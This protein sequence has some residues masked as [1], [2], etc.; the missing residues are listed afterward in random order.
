MEYWIIGY[1]N[2]TFQYSN[3]PVIQFA[4]LVADNSFFRFSRSQRQKII[5]DGLFQSFRHTL[6]IQFLLGLSAVRG[7]DFS[8]RESALP[9]R[10]FAFENDCATV[11]L[12]EQ[13]FDLGRSAGAE[14]R[15]RAISFI[16]SSRL[17]AGATTLALVLNAIG[18]KV[19]L[20]SCRAAHVA[21]AFI[22]LTLFHHLVE[23]L[24]RI[25]ERPSIQLTGDLVIEPVEK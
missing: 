6:G 18:R 20:A 13:A 9:G 21:L 24:L 5:L 16:L 11:A 12:A 8:L 4:T 19:V 10:R 14:F 25:Q 7:D 17:F 22:A 2:S 1:K 15:Q 23:K 3:T